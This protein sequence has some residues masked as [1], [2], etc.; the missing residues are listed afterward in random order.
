MRAQT[1]LAAAFC[2]MLALCSM[3]ALWIIVLPSTFRASPS[4]NHGKFLEQYMQLSPFRP[5][6]ITKYKSHPAVQYL[7]ILPAGIWS[8]C[9]P[10][11]LTPALRKSRPKLHK[12][13]GWAVVLCS[14]LMFLSVF[15]I[16]HRKL[17]FIDN[18]YALELAAFIA[19]A[20]AAPTL[21]NSIMMLALRGV[22]C[23]TALSAAW[24]L[25][26]IITALRCIV[27]RD[28]HSHRIW[29]V[30]H[31]G[32][33]IGVAVQRCYVLLTARQ[34]MSPTYQMLRFTEGIYIGF[35]LAV[36]GAELAA[37]C[38][39]QQSPGGNKVA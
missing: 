34:A 9:V 12:L 31:V 36:A 33:G 4:N 13:V 39:Q 25:L 23:F 30:R 3:M 11:Q 24:F 10:L 16:Q 2:V 19:H 20:A 14:V 17:D 7:H 32:S 21:Y 5:S 38:M 15:I 37:R 18:D 22:S 8:L 6:L 29:M 35:A 26:S 27:R 1:A 28:V